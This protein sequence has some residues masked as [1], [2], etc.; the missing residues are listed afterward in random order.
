[1]KWLVGIDEAGR[2]P[3]AG[4]VS[5]GAFAIP[6][7]KANYNTIFTTAQ[8]S[9][10]PNRDDFLCGVRDSKKLS[11]KQRERLFRGFQKMKKDGK[12]QFACS[13]VSNKIIDKRGISYAIRLALLRSLEKLKLKPDDCEVRLD[14]SLHAPKEY[15]NQKTIIHGD[16]LELVI[17]AAS[18]VA[19]VTRDRVMKKLAKKCP[20]YS[21]EVHKGYGT[22]KHYE[23]LKKYGPSAI[24][25]LTFLKKLT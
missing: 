18:I 2:G 15:T 25:R 13:L 8:R 9:L 7:N 3:L 6:I 24:H 5:V 1:M 4:P 17:G 16:D 19:K 10:A 21:F 20:N 23:N 22:K 14:G 12:A 11:E